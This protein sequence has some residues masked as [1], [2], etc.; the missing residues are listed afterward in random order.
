MPSSAQACTQGPVESIRF[1]S[2]GPK[3][4]GSRSRF[5]VNCYYQY[6]IIPIIL[7]TSLSIG[8]IV[9]MAQKFHLQWKPPPGE[10]RDACARRGGQLSLVFRKMYGIHKGGLRLRVSGSRVPCCGC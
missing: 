6:A 3:R 2:N 8:F 10:R 1:Q 5:N 9:M 7:T 4:A